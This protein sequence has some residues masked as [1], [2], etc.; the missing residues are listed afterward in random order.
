MVPNVQ[1]INLTNVRFDKKSDIRIYQYLHHFFDSIPSLQ[2]VT[3]H[4]CDRDMCLNGFRFHPT[5]T[6]QIFSDDSLFTITKFYLKH[7]SNLEEHDGIFLFYFLKSLECLSIRNAKYA[8]QTNGSDTIVGTNVPQ[9]VLIK[10]VRNAPTSMRWFR[11][12][13][14]KENIDMLTKERPGIELLN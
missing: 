4:H 1:E 14:T 12:N 10:F 6:K 8:I 7:M 11:S 5:Y 3:W 13:L 9:N 2:K